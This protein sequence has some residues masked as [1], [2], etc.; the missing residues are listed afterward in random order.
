MFAT[1]LPTLAVP[2]GSQRRRS[3]E[4][5]LRGFGGGSWRPS[6]T[7]SPCRALSVCRSAGVRG[8]GALPYRYTPGITGAPMLS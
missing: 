4:R 3:Y 6:S 5:K 8:P 7:G 2:M 1:C